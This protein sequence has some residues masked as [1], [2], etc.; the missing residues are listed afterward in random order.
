MVRHSLNVDQ[1][2]FVSSR[3]GGRNGKCAS[4][5]HD[6]QLDATASRMHRQCFL[7]SWDKINRAFAVLFNGQ[8]RLPHRFPALSNFGLAKFLSGFYNKRGWAFGQAR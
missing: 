2:R 3:V 7:V 8:L 1:D 5:F 4:F 6:A